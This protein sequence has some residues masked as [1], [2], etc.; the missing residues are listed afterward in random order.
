MFFF[1][2]KDLEEKKEIGFK[3]QEK[4]LDIVEIPIEAVAAYWLSLK[5]VSGKNWKKVISKEAEYT[6]EFF[7][8]HLLDLILSSFDDTSVRRYASFKMDTLLKELKRKFIIISIGLLGISSKEN[9]Q[10]VI[11]RIMSKFP[12][13]PTSDIKIFKNAQSLISSLEQGKR[14]FVQIYHGQHPEILITNLIFYSMLSRRKGVDFCIEY[15]EKV[16][17]PFFKEGLSLIRDGFDTEFIKYRLN[18]QQEEILYEAKQKMMMSIEMAI[19]LRHDIPYEDMFKIANSF[20][21]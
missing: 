15:S 10:Q 17:S 2:K 9:P 13:P 18:L 21:I 3:F 12:L 19:G 16:R 1:K 20:L 5:K 6:S 11:I 7:I 14:P 8:K 4:D